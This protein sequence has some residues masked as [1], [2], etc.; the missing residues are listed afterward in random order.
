MA[1]AAILALAVIEEA[2]V[3]PYVGIA[4]G[5]ILCGVAATTSDL[6][7]DDSPNLVMT[8]YPCRFSPD[9]TPVGGTQRIGWSVLLWE[10]G[11]AEA[12]S[13]YPLSISRNLPCL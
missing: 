1:L 4:T 11:R 7:I 5:V 3:C 9:G 8:L 2:R 10:L 13:S 6:V 12:S